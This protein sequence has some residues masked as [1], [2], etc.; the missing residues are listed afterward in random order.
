MI[1]DWIL[2]RYECLMPEVQVILGRHNAD[3]NFFNRSLAR[4]NGVERSKREILLIADGDTI[5]EAESIRAG[6]DALENAPWVIPYSKD[7]YFNIDIQSSDKIL[8]GNPCSQIRNFTWDHQLL[9][10]AGLLLIRREDFYKVGGYDERFVGWGH[11]DVAFRIKADHDLG[12]NVRS[13]G[14]A[15][16]LWH[17]RDDALFGTSE[18]IANRNLFDTE[19]RKKYHWVDE[20][21]KR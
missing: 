9:S 16:H 1:L 18:E 14:R 15:L 13:P 3:G 11:E 17:E 20:R 4:N 5:P 12:K 6:L 7:Q 10:W 2:S 21:L 19:Y 8:D